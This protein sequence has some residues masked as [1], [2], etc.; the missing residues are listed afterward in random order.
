[1]PALQRR[2]DAKAHFQQRFA[3]KGLLLSNFK[4][5][6][7]DANFFSSSRI[8]WKEQDHCL[9][10][11]VMHENIITYH[12]YNSVPMLVYRQRPFRTGQLRETTCQLLGQCSDSKGGI[13]W[14]LIYRLHFGSNVS[15]CST[16]YL[17]QSFSRIGITDMREAK[18]TYLDFV[19]FIFSHRRFH[20]QIFQFNIIVDYPLVVDVTQAF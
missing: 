5:D 14:S 2:K 18:I 9:Q 3:F 19:I 6:L 10:F 4:Q 16:F 8:F 17:D 13:S 15:H 12:I 11:P 7:K 20:Q 1:M